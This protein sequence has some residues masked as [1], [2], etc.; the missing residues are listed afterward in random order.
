MLYQLSYASPTTTKHCR[1]TPG[2]PR[3][4]SG[5][6]HNTAQFLRLA[7]WKQPGKPAYPQSIAGT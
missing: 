4:H 7:Q 2:N 6:A 1:E 5:S 3:T